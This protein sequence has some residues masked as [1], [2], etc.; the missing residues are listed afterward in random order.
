MNDINILLMIIISILWFLILKSIEVEGYSNIK[1]IKASIKSNESKSWNH[2]DIRSKCEKL[3][4]IQLPY[5]KMQFTK[6]FKNKEGIECNCE[7][8]GEYKKE[9]IGCP[10]SDSIGGSGCFIFNNQEAKEKCPKICNKYLPGKESKWTGDYRNVSIQT[11][12][13]ECEYYE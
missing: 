13:C 12:A 8:D 3:C 10:L 5:N 6:G 11:G 2:R 1:T 4:K 7:Y 9:Y